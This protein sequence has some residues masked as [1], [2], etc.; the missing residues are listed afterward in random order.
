MR[1][2]P[3]HDSRHQRFYLELDYRGHIRA[4]SLKRAFKPLKRSFGFGEILAHGF[5]NAE[6]A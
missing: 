3:T 2:I 4:L 5:P 6:A 1:K